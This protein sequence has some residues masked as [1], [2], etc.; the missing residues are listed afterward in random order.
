VESPGQFFPQ[1]FVAESPQQA[2]ETYIH[3]KDTEKVLVPAEFQ[4]V[5]PNYLGAVHIDYLPVEYVPL[6]EDVPFL[7]DISRYY[8]RRAM[9]GNDERVEKGD[10]LPGDGK[11]LF[12]PSHQKMGDL[13][14]NCS[15]NHDEIMELADL[16][17]QFVNDGLAEYG[18]QVEFA[19]YDIHGKLRK[20]KALSGE[21]GLSRR[22]AQ[23]PP[24]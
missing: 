21:K 17:S 9:Y 5:Y 8:F 12:T 19:H 4:I 13:R 6:D 10:I 22:A 24:G 3:G 2:P 18:A 20:K 16:P 7:R 1:L 11:V 14:E 15:G 23:F